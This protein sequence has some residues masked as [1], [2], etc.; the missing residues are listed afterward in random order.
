M[1][2]VG[3]A[4]GHYYAR[5][6]ERQL[7]AR[8]S[9]DSDGIIIGAR[10][11]AR[12]G[13]NGAAVMLVHGAGDT[14]Q[15][16]WHLADEL[17]RRGYAVEAPLLPG[18]GRTLAALSMYSADDWY[19]CVRDHYSRLR[20]SHA[21]VGVVGLSMGGALCAQ[22]AG[23]TPDVPALVLASPYLAMPRVADIMTRTSWLWGLLVPYVPTA[24]QE[25]VLDPSARSH[26]LSYGAMSTSAL[27]A[28]RTTARRGWQALPEINA[29]TLI[30]Q[31][32]RDNRV[33][34][35]TTRRAYDHLSVREKEVVWIEGAGHVITVDFGWERVVSV[36]ADWMDS[37]RTGG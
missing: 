21:W 20:E 8:Y 3:W 22:L 27:R 13:S 9:R 11:I 18:H 30:L 26:G 37:H 32:T 10:D 31:S 15:T 12:A 23:A 28:L 24:S 35:D 14:P 7:G 33:D 16:M 17:E 4:V 36:I 1:V 29:P 19:A 2:P 6:L 25:S 34:S 5:S